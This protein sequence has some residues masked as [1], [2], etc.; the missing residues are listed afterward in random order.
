M[1]RWLFAPIYG[2]IPVEFESAFNIDEAVERLS[3]VSKWF[4]I[5]RPLPEGDVSKHFVSLHKPYLLFTFDFRGGFEPY[6]KG[7]FSEA[8]GR[9]RLLG[10]FTLGLFA[11]V[12]ATVW[13]GFLV[14]WT[15]ITMRSLFIADPRTW[16]FPFVGAGMFALGVAY[17]AIAK[18][19]A[20]DD[21]RWLS[22]RIENALSK[23]S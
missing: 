4:A 21:I 17:V 22:E 14:L 6:F 15:S 18:W 8:D 19:S 12:F 13:L 1:L 11:K 2:G 16:W 3:A 9:V 23:K 10:R 20:R 7:E 5:C